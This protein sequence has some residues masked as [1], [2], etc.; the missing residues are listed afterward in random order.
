[1]FDVLW[2]GKLL[3]IQV[4]A[5]SLVS[6]RQSNRDRSAFF[7]VSCYCKKKLLANHSAKAE[8]RQRA[9]HLAFNTVH[10]ANSLPPLDPIT[11]LRPS[12][13]TRGCLSHHWQNSQQ[14]LKEARGRDQG[15]PRGRGWRWLQCELKYDFSVIFGSR[16]DPADCSSSHLATAAPTGTRKIRIGLLPAYLFGKYGSP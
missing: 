9:S 13:L 3:L 4:E 7:T 2:I 5:A 16:M 6:I 8:D 14:T 12:S 10:H 11:N 15:F 1:M